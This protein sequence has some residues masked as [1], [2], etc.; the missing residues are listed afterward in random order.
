MITVENTES[1]GYQFR[2]ITSSGTTLL[3]SIAFSTKNELQ[4]TVNDLSLA[5]VSTRKVERKTNHQGKFLFQLKNS[6]GK[7]L[8]TSGLY[9][10]EAGMENGIK[11]LYHN[12]TLD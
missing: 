7:V 8:G 10:S 2:V 9:S 5:S 3:K 1:K 12:L 4:K 11:N 6:T